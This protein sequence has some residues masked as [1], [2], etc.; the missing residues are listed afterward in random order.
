MM[1][2]LKFTFNAFQE[3]TYILYD[4]KNQGN[5]QGVIIDPGMS[6]PNEWEEV[7]EALEAHS[8]AL[9]SIVLSHGHIDH[10]LGIHRL[11]E[12]RPSMPIYGHKIT[13][14]VLNAQPE[15]AAL[16]G[17]HLPSAPE[18]THFLEPGKQVGVGEA[19]LDILYTPGHCPGE[20][21]FY[22]ASSKTLIAG[23]VLFY[24]SIGRTDLPGG[25]LPTLLDAIREQFWPLPDDTTV[26]CGH[27]PETTIGYEKVHNPFL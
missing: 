3:N 17:I 21:S 12:W 5:I 18:I 4:D 8:I 27:G 7:M 26:Y 25:D 15:Y 19:T 6:N 14:E 23:D 13:Q 20:V 1:R 2:L 10:I 24:E 9:Q 11:L 16:F 22:H